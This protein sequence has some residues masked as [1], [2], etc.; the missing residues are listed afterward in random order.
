MTET[1]TRVGRATQ[2][3]W[4]AACRQ[5]PPSVPVAR[6][7]LSAPA[8]TEKYPDVEPYGIDTAA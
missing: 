2:T 5:H 1:S 8:E 3:L 6:Y 7:R 4:S